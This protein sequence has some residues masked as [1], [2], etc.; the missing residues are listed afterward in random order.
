MS[1]LYLIKS[2][3]TFLIVFQ[4]LCGK[5]KC[6]MFTSNSHDSRAMINVLLCTVLHAFAFF[7]V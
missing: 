6:I 2:N 1:T 4:I 7:T 5:A 3:E